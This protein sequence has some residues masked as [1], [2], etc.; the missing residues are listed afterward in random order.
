M[1]YPFLSSMRQSNWNAT[2]TFLGGSLA[3]NADNY[4]LLDNGSEANP[5]V[6]VKVLKPVRD[7]TDTTPTRLRVSRFG[8]ALRCH[9]RSIGT[10][11]S[12]SPISASRLRCW[13]G[14]APSVRMGKIAVAQLT[15]YDAKRRRR[16][17]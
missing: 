5:L 16:D 8:T 7:D 12:E 15:T 4:A 2:G 17:R 11:T 13:S 1:P 10:A 9:R 3:V 14:R 6:Q